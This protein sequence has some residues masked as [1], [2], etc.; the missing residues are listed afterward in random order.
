VYQDIE[1]P[2]SGEVSRL[3]SQRLFELPACIDSI[4]LLTKHDGEIVV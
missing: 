2:T 4:S 3:E 1:A